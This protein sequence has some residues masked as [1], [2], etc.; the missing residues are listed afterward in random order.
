MW[1]NPYNVSDA[2]DLIR[3]PKLDVPLWSENLYFFA[4]DGAA[5]LCVFAHMSR[6]SPDPRVW[7]GNL[8]ITLPDGTVLVNRSIGYSP[9]LAW[10]GQ[11]GLDCIEPNRRWH[12]HFN[13][14]AQHTDGQQLATSARLPDARVPVE[15]DLTFYAVHPVW[16]KED[17][18]GQDG[19]DFHIE[20]GGR[21][22]GRVR[23]G[24]EI[25]SMDCTGWRDHSAGPRSYESL[26]GNIM[27]ACIFPSHKT[28]LATL[29]WAGDSEDIHLHNFGYIVDG[30]HFQDLTIVKA[31]TLS[32]P[33]NMPRS[34]SFELDVGGA[35]GILKAEALNS[36]THTLMRPQGMEFGNIPIDPQTALFCSAPTRYEWQG[37]VG[38]G[39][40]DRAFRIGHF[41]G[42]VPFPTL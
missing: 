32:S 27:A 24:D 13:G 37:E 8:A 33:D 19:A 29:I 39:W 38:Y 17:M 31:P 21:F 41:T 7:E 12:W 40:M 3:T 30:D 6:L 23:W 28:L 1:S 15:L 5:G 4:H 34:V 42:A 25:V 2:E 26:Q 11:L 16:A 18:D 10:T 35:R 20:Q 22:R 14:V 36:I 9:N